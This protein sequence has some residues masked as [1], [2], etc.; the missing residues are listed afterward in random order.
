M[1]DLFAWWQQDCVVLASGDYLLATGTIAG[2]QRVLRRL[3]TSPNTYIWHP[4]YGAGLP[5]YVGQPALVD[6]VTSLAMAQMML[7]DAVSSS[8]LPK[9]SAKKTSAGYLNMDIRYVDAN[10]GEPTSMNFNV[11]NG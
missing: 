4:E 7:E 9:V 5:G 11:S 2:E 1:A 10:T 6:A 8:P 3:L